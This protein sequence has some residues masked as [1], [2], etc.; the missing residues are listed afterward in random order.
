MWWSRYKTSGSRCSARPARL[1]CNCSTELAP[2]TAVDTTGSRSSHASAT[3]AGLA[4]SHGRAPRKP[5]AG[6]GSAARAA[7]DHSRR[8][9]SRRPRAR[10]PGARRAAG[11]RR[12]VRCPGC[13]GCAPAPSRRSAW[14]GCQGTAGDE[15]EE[16]PHVSGR[17]GEGDVPSG[18]VAASYVDPLP[19]RT[20]VCSR[21]RLASHAL[22]TC[23][24]TGAGR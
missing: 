10:R 12:S 13:A 23:M 17:L 22:R 4:P 1:A 14:A 5:R 8:H 24:R 16:L 3:W 11:C 2:T 15:P 20:T 18:E 9:R 6:C 21:R 7:V 19:W